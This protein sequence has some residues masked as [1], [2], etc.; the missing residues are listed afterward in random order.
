MVSSHAPDASYTPFPTIT[1]QHPTLNHE[2]IMES[3]NSHN[4][5]ADQIIISFQAL[6]VM[7]GVVNFKSFCVIRS[8]RCREAILQNLISITHIRVQVHLPECAEKAMN[9]EQ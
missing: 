1:A 6:R 3:E 7:L 4:Y 8:R 9:T 5:D 2:V